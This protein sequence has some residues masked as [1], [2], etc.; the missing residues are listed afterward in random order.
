MR[1]RFGDPSPAPGIAESPDAWG[2][3]FHIPCWNILTGIQ[4]Q[5]SLNTQ[6]LFNFL[7]SFPD[8]LGVLYFGHNYGGLLQHR[9]LPGR[10]AAGDNEFIL[11]HGEEP[12]H[13]R[14]DPFNIP[15][16]SRFFTQEH[17]G[18]TRDDP[19]PTRSYNTDPS[20]DPFSKLPNEILEGILEFLP[21]AHVVLLKQASP[22]YANLALTESF[23]RSRFLQHQEFGFVFE[24]FQHE[25]FMRGNWKSLYSLVSTLHSHPAMV[26]R[27]R[28][29]NLACSLR[30][31]LEHTTGGECAGVPVQSFFEP[32]AP[33]DHRQWVTATRALRAPD[34]R[35][36]CGRRS[37]WERSLALPLGPAALFVSSVEEFGR[38]Y[39]SGLRLESDDNVCYSLGYN[40]PARET[41]FCIDKGLVA[42]FCLAQDER[43]VRGIAVL[44]GTGEWS[45]WIGDSHNLPKRKLVL[46]STQRT[47]VRFLKAGFD[48]S[49]L[50]TSSFSYLSN[51]SARPLSLSLYQSRMELRAY[52]ASITTEMR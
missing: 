40:N 30:E 47:T 10:V 24:S 29:W 9:E 13:A 4:S 33:V 17:T 52:Q 35:F 15:D 51:F 22:A 18:C 25:S 1:S 46:N 41:R 44:L 6:D 27:K 39:V 42:G 11:Y 20:R 36:R 48:V 3:P 28:V 43:G 49:A 5:S 50:T 31:A 38:F 8:H 26:N 21:S 2:F 19:M 12:E 23:W 32:S 37:L 16:L 34:A 45:R 7:R 14:H